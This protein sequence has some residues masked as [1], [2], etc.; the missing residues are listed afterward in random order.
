MIDP[1]LTVIIPAYNCADYIEE[2]V[3]SVLNQT[4]SDFEVIVIDDVSTDNSLQLLNQ[5]AAADSRIRI[6]S[7]ATNAGQ[8]ACR[9]RGVREARGRYIAF[10]DADDV[11]LP[12]KLERQIEFM[13][14]RKLPFCFCG[15]G[16]INEHGDTIIGDLKIP[17]RTEFYA[18]LK[19]NT[20]CASSVVYDRQSMD[21]IVMPERPR[22]REDLI[23][24]LA[25]SKAL[26]GYLYGVSDPLCMI[27]RLP[28]S[29]SSNKLRALRWQWAVYRE[30][31]GF[32][33]LRSFYYLINFA[34]TSLAKRSPISV[35]LKRRVK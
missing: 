27:R 28:G 18:L 31:L 25:T 26:G 15:Y 35:A 24:W 33:L 34:I 21:D 23:S 20:I 6:L 13:T 12:R 10:L 8:A 1:A 3:N 30:V 16:T 2:T 32:G 9:N 5:L 14:E 22:R 17:E 19:S 29:S 7:S 11:W 4:F